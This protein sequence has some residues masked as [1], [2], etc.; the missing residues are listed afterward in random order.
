MGPTWGQQDPS[1]PHVGHVNLAI[2]E[3]YYNIAYNMAVANIEHDWCFW[4]TKDIH[5]FL[6]WASCGMSI[7]IIFKKTDFAVMRDC[8]VILMKTYP[9]SIRQRTA[10]V[11]TED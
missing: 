9:L 1:G 10:A 3:F 6:L 11:D 7:V 8:T 2:W 4:L 5:S